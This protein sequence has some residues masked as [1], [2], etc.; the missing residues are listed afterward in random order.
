MDRVDLIF[1]TS[2]GDSLGLVQA[3][4]KQA[5]DSKN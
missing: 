4:Y 1:I 2:G 5:I 3:E